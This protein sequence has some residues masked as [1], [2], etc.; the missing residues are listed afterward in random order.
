MAGT[1]HKEGR[2][3]GREDVAA[4]TWSSDTSTQRMENGG[5]R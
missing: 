5:L 4:V 3:G 2:E 1:E